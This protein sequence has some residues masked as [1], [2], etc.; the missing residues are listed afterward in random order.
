[1]TVRRRAR[2]ATTGAASAAGQPAA[3]TTTMSQRPARRGV[4]R[5]VGRRERVERGADAAALVVRAGRQHADDAR[6]LGAGADDAQRG[7]I[8]AVWSRASVKAL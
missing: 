7:T 3:T 4:A 5:E 2:P 1:M 6:Q 8:S